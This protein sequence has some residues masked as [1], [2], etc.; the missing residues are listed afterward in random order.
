MQIARQLA[1]GMEEQK[2][3]LD[4]AIRVLWTHKEMAKTGYGRDAIDDH[5]S[6]LTE[7]KFTISQTLGKLDRDE[8]PVL[9]MTD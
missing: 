1:M 9:A 2:A 3:A 8:L 4:A 7:E 6:E 5:I